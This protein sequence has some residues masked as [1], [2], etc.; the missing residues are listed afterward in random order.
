LAGVSS[1]I[2]IND[3]L[4]SLKSKM[5]QNSLKQQLLNLQLQLDLKT[6]RVL[7]SSAPAKT[8]IKKFG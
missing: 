6:Q 1:A 8:H 4:A 3:N 2:T 5:N 7:K